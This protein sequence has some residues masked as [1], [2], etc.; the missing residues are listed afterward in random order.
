M[1][2]IKNIILVAIFFFTLT[3]SI[4]TN[5]LNVRASLPPGAQVELDV[6]PHV[7]MGTC[8]DY[9]YGIQTPDS[10]CALKYGITAKAGANITP[11]GCDCACF[12][13]RTQCTS[14][15]HYN[16]CWWS[17]YKCVEKTI[18]TCLIT[19]SPNGIEAGEIKDITVSWSTTNAIGATLGDGT[20]VTPNT[21]GTKIYPGV[22]TAITYTLNVT[23]D[24]NISCH[25]DVGIIVPPPPL[26]PPL[27]PVTIKPMS[28][29][30]TGL[31][32]WLLALIAGLAILFLIIGG[33]MYI[34][35]SEDKQRMQMA[36][37]IMKYSVIGLVIVLISYSVIFTLDKIING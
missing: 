28:E 12:G 7:Y 27:E 34:V 2:K 16:T 11:V 6:W 20:V 31:I 14:S 22:S 1:H 25:V 30:I 19:A 13:M 17:T 8:F 9:A 24:T 10:A 23:G 37:N 36:K 35:S 33:I 3:S 15:G 29:I 18:P 4:I 26:K 32:D 5:T 21:T